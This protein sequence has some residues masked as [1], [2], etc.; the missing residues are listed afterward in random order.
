MSK[1]PSAPA[2]GAPEEKQKRIEDEARAKIMERAATASEDDHQAV[3]AIIERAK[4]G[5]YD[6]AAYHMTAGMAALLFSRHNL[7]NRDWSAHGS[8]GSL[9]YARRML[10]DE[11]RPN[12]D[13]IRFYL[14]GNLADGQGRIGGQALAGI[15]LDVLIAFG[16]DPDAVA[17]IDDG[18]VRQGADTAQLQGVEDAKAKQTVLR[19]A[20]NYMVRL[21]DKQAKIRSNV[22]MARELAA[23][24][25]ML[26]TALKVGIASSEK[27]SGAILKEST[28]AVLAYLMMKYGGWT[29]DLTKYRLRQIQEGIVHA[30][31]GEKVP[32]FIANETIKKARVAKESRDRLQPTEEVALVLA[33]LKAVESKVSAI[34]PTN[35]KAMIKK[36]LPTPLHPSVEKMPQAAE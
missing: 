24:N 19:Q 6:V 34:T 11:W 30:P 36:E 16:I 22:E 8:K 2:N 28:A 31:D 26:E 9:E 32:Y 17:T 5:K 27:V 20:T 21:G 14:N 35:L 18:R 13:T 15:S 25:K 12:G 1:A 33:A 10:E 7:F 29:V 4:S 23:N 3:A